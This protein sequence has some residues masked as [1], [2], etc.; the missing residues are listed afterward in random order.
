MAVS[1]EERLPLQASEAPSGPAPLSNSSDRLGMSFDKRILLAGFSSFMCGFTLGASH[2]G[3]M[4][5]MRFRAENA[6]RLPVSRPGWYLYHKSK[7]YYKVK[8]GVVVGI[9]R[10]FHLA[11]W[12]SIFFVIEESMDIFRGTWMAGRTLSEMEGIDELD[13]KKM[14]QS[15][16]NNRDFISSALAGMVTGG[17]WSA[18]NTFPMVTAAR[19]IKT[20]LLVGIGYGLGQDALI[21]ARKK[22][23]VP[24][25]ESWIYKNSR[26]SMMAAQQ[27]P[28]VAEE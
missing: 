3:H 21:W 15:V 1:T 20:G 13:M 12:T 18:W 28:T 6:H 14:D 27:E 8:E 22:Y 17:L 25:G 4:A 5:A 16:R 11:A 23:G 7:N 10:G 26:K 2:A 19:T 9:R 24:V